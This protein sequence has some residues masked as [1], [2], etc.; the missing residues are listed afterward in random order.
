MFHKIVKY[1]D[2]VVLLFAFFVLSVSLYYT[3]SLSIFYKKKDAVKT[4]DNAL[5]LAKNLLEEEQRHAMSLSLLISQDKEFLKAYYANNKKLAFDTIN[6]KIK[7]LNSIESY[8]VDVQVHDKNSNCYLKSWDY[9]ATSLPLA[10]FREGIVFVKQSKKP[11][12]SIEVGKRLNIKAISPILKDGKFE[13]SVEVIEGFGHLLEKLLEHGYITF[14]LLNKKFLPIATSLKNHQ[15][16]QNKFLLVND[17]YEKE[18]LNALQNSDLSSLGSY[19]YFSK[20]KFFFGYFG[21]RNLHNK[22]IGYC[23]IS[24]E[25]TNST[26][27]TNYHQNS[28]VKQTISG[29]TIR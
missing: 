13:G 9:N 12:V 28:A 5:V 15:K 18:G 8:P 22:N 14:I 4:L 21:I 20:E 10:S 7:I 17:T 19:G 23:I 6:K 3:Y 26:Y 2:R 25:N 24:P 16:I 1:I 11:I 29:V 27:L